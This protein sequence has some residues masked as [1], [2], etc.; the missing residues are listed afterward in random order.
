MR[1]GTK[2]YNEARRS[3]VFKTAAPVLTADLAVVVETE[4]L[5]AR[6]TEMAPGRRSKVGQ[7][8]IERNLELLSKEASRRGEKRMKAAKEAY[9][10]RS[11]E[12]EARKMRNRPR[13]AL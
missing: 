8:T 1:A 5:S 3:R 9:V 13:P 4:I 11:R 10:V 2:P 7:K 12:I 6:L